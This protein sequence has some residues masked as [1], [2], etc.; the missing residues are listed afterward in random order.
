MDSKANFA[1]WIQSASHK[2]YA[3]YFGLKRFEDIAKPWQERLKETLSN[4]KIPA[5]IIDKVIKSGFYQIDQGF[6]EDSYYGNKVIFQGSL[7][8]SE[9]IKHIK[10]ESILKP[11]NNIVEVKVS[12][13]SE[14]YDTITEMGLDMHLKEGYLSFRGQQNDYFTKREVSN[15]YMANELGQ[16]RLIIPGDWRK[17]V[18]D[19]NERY[20][21]TDPVPTLFYSEDLIYDGIENW[22]DLPNENFAKYGPHTLSDLED[23][24]DEKSQEYFKRWIGHRVETSN[25]TFSVLE[26]HYIASTNGLDVT[27]SLETALFF[28]LNKFKIKE[29]KKATYTLSPNKN[30]VVYLFE[31]RLPRLT[32]TKDLIKDIDIF[33][34]LNPIRPIRQEC[35][36]PFFDAFHFNE[37]CCYLKAIFHV[38]DFKEVDKL[39]SP[40]YLFPTTEDKFY[41]KLLNAATHNIVLHPDQIPQYEF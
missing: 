27:F 16:E 12:T 36:L 35:A 1:E 31:F 32:K 30:S 15:P 25:P 5:E 38:E 23:F 33:K 4:E 26:Q 40:V 21:D 29:N 3:N 22:E 41:Q 2:E 20:F 13:L 10:S 6:I 39:P 17:F 11:S 14:I 8:T 28:A 7:P 19:F 24:D 18:D 34:H 37:A 9:F